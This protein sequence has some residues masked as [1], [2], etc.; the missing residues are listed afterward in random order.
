MLLFTGYALLSLVLQVGALVIPFLGMAAVFVGNQIEAG[1]YAVCLRP[2]R[3]GPVQVGDVLAGFGPEY[4]RLTLCKLIQTAVQ[5]G[6]TL[7]LLIGLAPVGFIWW[8]NQNEA[9]LPAPEVLVALLLVGLVVSLLGVFGLFYFLVSWL[10]AAPL[11]LD[12]GLGI[13]PALECSRRWINRH[14]WRLSWLLLVVSTYGSAGLLLA[15]VGVIYTGARAWAMLAVLYED[16]AGNAPSA[17]VVPAS[18]GPRAET[19]QPG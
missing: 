18:A 13:W 4:W 10:F 9:A 1:M 11:V 12:R 17:L 14:P 3:G 19:A 5:T 7:L 15:G 6:F 2:L 16:L 8:A